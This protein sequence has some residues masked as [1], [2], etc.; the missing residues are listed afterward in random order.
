MVG[1]EARMR[2]SSV[3]CPSASNGTLKSTRMSTRFPA[4]SI[5]RT[6]FLFI[7][8]ILTTC[9]IQVSQEVSLQ[10]F[11]GNEIREVGDAAGIAPLVVV[12]GHDLD[13]V[14]AKHHR[15]ETI[16]DSRVCVT[17]KI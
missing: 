3:T 4:T 8:V 14:P 2:V 7:H 11:F 12:P 5:S 1:R 10:A 9:Y 13:H 17:A 6:V 16:N 15:R